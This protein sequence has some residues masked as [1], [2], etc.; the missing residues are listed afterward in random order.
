ML[1]LLP[2]LV[3]SVLGRLIIQPLT[4]ATAFYKL[5]NVT[6]ESIIPWAFCLSIFIFLIAMPQTIRTYI[7]REKVYSRRFEKKL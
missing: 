5:G 4:T 7:Y 6:N 1:F 3:V 2:F